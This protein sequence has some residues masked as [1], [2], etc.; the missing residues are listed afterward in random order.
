M[1]PRRAALALA[2]AAAVA[3]SLSPALAA[4]TAPAPAAEALAP[5]PSAPEPF[6]VRLGP[7]DPP[8]RA[9]GSVAA[10]LDAAPAGA[11]IRV[12]AGYYGERLVIAKAVTI[13][14]AAGAEGR[15]VIE[16]QTELPYEATV[17]VD[18]PGVALRGLKLRHA[19]PSVA[20]DYCVLIRG[21]AELE[22]CDISSATGSGLGVEG[23]VVTATAC[24]LSG[25][26]LHGAALY[27]DLAGEAAGDCVLSACQLEENG[28]CGALVRD[29]ASA[30]LRSC[31]LGRNGAF[32]LEVVDAS[33][34]LVGC[35]VRANRK[36]ALLLERPRGLDMEA[37]AIDV[38]PVVRGV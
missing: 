25:N 33:V 27:G 6:T 21:G 4:T 22:R 13:E 32:G 38:A 16:H 14:A 12:E 35:T 36:G 17:Q 18:A 28:A 31:T 11:T 9:Y 5:P 8:S 23:G 34:T 19:S 29:G 30:A 26:K 3:L 7:D 2:P 24:K 20:S 37:N 1:L 10:A 15:V